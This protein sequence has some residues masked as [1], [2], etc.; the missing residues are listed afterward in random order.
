MLGIVFVD[1]RNTNFNSINMESACFEKAFDFL[2]GEGLNI[3]EVVTDAHSAIARLMS[4]FNKD[5]VA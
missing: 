4:K 3:A 5:F 2:T 1:E